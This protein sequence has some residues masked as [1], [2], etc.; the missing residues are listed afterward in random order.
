MDVCLLWPVRIISFRDMMPSI[1]TYEVR[2]SRGEVENDGIEKRIAI[3]GI[4]L[5]Q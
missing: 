3:S 2:R 1:L 4:L 5:G